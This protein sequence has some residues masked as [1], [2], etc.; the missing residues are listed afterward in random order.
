[1][2]EGL[3]SSKEGDWEFEFCGKWASGKLEKSRGD[4]KKV[5]ANE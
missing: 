1:M 2:V 3:L 5:G 4:T